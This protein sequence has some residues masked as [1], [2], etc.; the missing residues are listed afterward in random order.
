[1]QLWEKLK[2]H[3]FYDLYSGKKEMWM[4]KGC[5]I[6]SKSNK[7]SIQINTQRS[8]DDDNINVLLKLK[9]TH[10]KSRECVGR[11]CVVCVLVFFVR[12]PIAFTKNGYIREARLSTLCSVCAEKILLAGKDFGARFWVLFMLMIIINF[13]FTAFLS[14]CTWKM[15]QISIEPHFRCRHLLAIFNFQLFW[16]QSMIQH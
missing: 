10:I 14:L 8:H 6:F 12:L 7:I 1:M 16:A 2:F 5:P 13:I 11:W 4:K 9:D 15:V 3:V